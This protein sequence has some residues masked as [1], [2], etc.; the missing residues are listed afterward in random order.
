MEEEASKA[1]TMLSGCQILWIIYD[2]LKI[3]DIEAHILEF[4]DLDR[5]RQAAPM[6]LS[7]E[8]PVFAVLR[9]KPI[10]GDTGPRSP[11]PAWKRVAALR[12]RLAK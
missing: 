11:G 4:D 5:W 7:S 1:G 12:D 6:V 2:F 10:S 8:G 9:V 3:S